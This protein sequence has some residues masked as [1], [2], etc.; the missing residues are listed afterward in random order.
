MNTRSRVSLVGYGD[1][2]K[3]PRAGYAGGGFSR[4]G[5]G[6]GTDVCRLHAGARRAC[7]W[8]SA[9]I[10]GRMVCSSGWMP[11]REIWN[12]PARDSKESGAK[13]GLR[14]FQANFSSLEELLGEIGIPKVDAILADLGI[15]TNQLFDWSRTE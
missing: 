13:C 9:G 3:R 11:T 5:A 1:S 2:K 8:K 10:W 15:S 6:N 7:R 12:L 14:L 4:A